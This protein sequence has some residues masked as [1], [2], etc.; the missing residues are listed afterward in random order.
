M[1]SKPAYR[2][3]WTDSMEAGVCLRLNRGT[4]YSW[5]RNYFSFVSRLG[6]GGI[7]YAI[8]A[9]I[10]L[11]YGLDALPLSLH[12][13][14]TGLVGVAI[15]KL[16]KLTLVRERPF[17][18]HAQITCVGQPMDRGSFPSGHTIHA[19]SFTLILNSVFPGSAWVMFPFALSIAL[20][21][22]VLGHHY[23]SDVLAGAVIGF[24]LGYTSLLLL[25]GVSYL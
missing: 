7:W 22:V 18:S 11:V 10:P 6:N 4:R 3:R 16:C 15:Y 24:C 25:P 9:C 17:V 23:P 2:F 21:R 1:T 19:A 20:S 8:L 12:I 14:L 5:V 13:A